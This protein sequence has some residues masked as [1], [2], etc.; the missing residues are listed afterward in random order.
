MP[1]PGDLVL[2]DYRDQEKAAKAWVAT[3]RGRPVRIV[4][5]NI[6][7]GYKFDEIV[8]TLKIVDADILLLQEIDVG[9]DRSGGRDVG[10]PR[11]VKRLPPSTL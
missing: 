6:E 10:A 2:Q 7:R 1:K 9:C 5:W 4:Q 11:F 3:A 8:Q